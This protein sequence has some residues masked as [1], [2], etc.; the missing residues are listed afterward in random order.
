MCHPT[1]PRPNVNAR[2][3]LT[4][5]I[6]EV[7][8]GD[9]LEIDLLGSG[10][11]RLYSTLRYWH[12]GSDAAKVV[13]ALELLDV[14]IERL[15]LLLQQRTSRTSRESWVPLLLR[16]ELVE[17]LVEHSYIPGAINHAHLVI[18]ALQTLLRALR[19]DAAW[20][21]RL[22]SGSLE[23]L[24]IV[25][26]GCAAMA[27][28][29]ESELLTHETRLGE[30][31]LVPLCEGLRVNNI[32]ELTRGLELAA[33]ASVEMNEVEIGL[34]VQGEVASVVRGRVYGDV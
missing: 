10:T 32:D 8:P 18:R 6:P 29:V 26:D 9:V 33:R 23:P 11:T 13:A 34:V 16:I 24:R 4:D 20:S 15:W 25:R 28:E 17:E 22:W 19:D 7:A 3:R 14:V 30:P 1:D 12:M 2:M 5:D 27:R 21:S 31:R